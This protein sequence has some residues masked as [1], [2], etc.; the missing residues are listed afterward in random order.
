[1]F[2]KTNGYSP[3]AQDFIWLGEYIDGTHLAEFDFVTK[4]ENSFY[5]L[6]KDKLF[7]FGL[8][9]GGLRMFYDPDGRF[10]IAG[11]VVDFVYATPEKEYYL[12]SALYTTNRDPITYKDATA[13]L[14]SFNDPNIQSGLASNSTIT[15]YTFGYKSNVEIDGVKFNFKALCKVP[16]NEPIYMNLRLVSDTELDG[17]FQ[18]RVGGVVVSEFQSPLKTNVGG[19]LNWLVQ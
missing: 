4:E 12:T 1:M 11:R 15:Q 6:N 5:S 18:I 17:K 2:T 3:V 16:F 7:L 13:K 14:S 8:V 10:N 19:E 9:G